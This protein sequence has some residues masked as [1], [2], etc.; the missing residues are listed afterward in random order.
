MKRF[1]FKLQRLLDLRAAQEK[2]V[3]NELAELVHIQNIERN[4]QN[5]YR[6]KIAG[7]KD[8]LR[9]KLERKTASYDDVLMHERFLDS[10]DKAIRIAEQKIQKMEP[11]IQK[12]RERLI[13][14]SRE[15]KI[16]AKLKEKKYQEYLYNINREI[17]KENDDMNQKLYHKHL[18]DDMYQ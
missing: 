14:A 15:K 10:A 4:K 16:V 9:Q 17:N 6:L 3:K 2:A 5:E 18:A 8:I 1:Q 7:R 12:V 13:E 11:A